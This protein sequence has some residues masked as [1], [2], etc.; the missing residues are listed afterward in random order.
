MSAVPHR[1]HQPPHIRLDCEPLE[2]K[3]AGQSHIEFPP[4]FADFRWV[5]GQRLR[6]LCG[7]RLSGPLGG[8]MAWIKTGSPTTATTG[9][10]PATATPKDGSAPPAPSPPAGPPNAPPTG[11]RPKS[12]RA[13]GTTTPAARSPSPST[14]RPSGSLQAGRDLHP[15]G[16]P[17][18]PRQALHPHLRPRPMGK[19]LPSEIQRWVTTATENGL[20][21]ASVRQVPHHAGTRSSNAPCATGSSPSTPAPT[22]SCP[23]GQEEDPDPDPRRVRRH[24]RRAARPAS[25]DGR[26]R[27][28]HRP[29][30]GR[31]H[32][33]QT[34]PPRPHQAH[35]DR[36][37]DNRGGL[38]QE[39]PHRRSGC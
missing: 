6:T 24:P 5:S 4:T 36:R 31:A 27:D 21:A 30:V 35:A 14:S 2:R 39:L 3:V 18:L 38:D 20:S 10:S 34:P 15:G 19:I 33:P 16:L 8:T 12:A 37:R 9:S 22:P 23:R 28:Q 11:R 1:P 7:H 13:P 29:A 26:D 25:V 32:R 17:V